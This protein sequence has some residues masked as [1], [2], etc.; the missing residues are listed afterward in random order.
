MS[1]I[2]INIFS[3]F[4]IFVYWCKSFFRRFPWFGKRSETRMH[5]ASAH[6]FHTS[7]SLHFVC[8]VLSLQKPLGLNIRYSKNCIISFFNSV[9]SSC[10]GV[11]FPC[12][13][14]FSASVIWWEW[15]RRQ[16]GDDWLLRET[17]KKT[18]DP[19]TSMGYSTTH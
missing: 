1:R 10:C 4:G 19:L 14:Y 17:F 13:V 2:I 11:L 7:L 16:V 3:D 8:S 9:M 6:V 18:Q 12:L 5:H 15:K